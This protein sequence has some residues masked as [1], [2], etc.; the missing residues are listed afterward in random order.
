MADTH[1]LHLSQALQETGAD[2]TSPTHRRRVRRWSLA[3]VLVAVAIILGLEGYLLWQVRT[4]AWQMALRSAENVSATLTLGI[5]RNLKTVDLSLTGLQETIEQFDLSGLEPQLRN[6]ALFDRAGAAEYLGAMLVIGKDGEVLFDNAGWPPR[7]GNYADRDYFRA[8]V[9]APK[10]THISPPYL[11]RLRPGDPSFGLSRRWTGPD[12][13]FQGVFLGAIRLAYFSSL[14][15]EVKLGPKAA[16]SIVRDDGTVLMRVPSSDGTGNVGFNLA[17]SPAMEHV[18]AG[19]QP[20]FTARSTIDG[21]ERVFI[22]SQIGQFPLY[23]LVGFSSTDVVDSWIPEAI[24]ISGIGLI[25]C[26]IIIGLFIWLQFALD[27]Q[28]QVERDL[29]RLATTDVLTNLANRR[30]FDATIGREWERSRRQMATISLLLI[31]V[32]NFKS[33]NDRLGHPAG[34]TLLRAISA[35]ISGA[36]LRPG[37]MAARY[38]GDEFAVLLSQTDARGAITVAR[39]VQEHIARA[40]GAE[41]QGLAAGTVSIGTATLQVVPDT[42]AAVED[43]FRV[44][45]RAL[46]RAKRGGRNRIEVGMM[47]DL[48]PVDAAQLA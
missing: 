21:E 7:G 39:R 18:R 13:S 44:A 28:I 17:G 48:H 16:V 3:A 33:I 2:R 31:D 27:R 11:S 14:F 9:E 29:A 42:F 46:Y 36:L 4:A 26:L 25:A 6:S 32:D 5:E 22:S 8:H 19:T 40:R 10:G 1:R 12:G 41:L 15:S 34:D 35:A 38:G 47:E 20:Y 37:D 24:T 45:D 23:L 30:H 43:L